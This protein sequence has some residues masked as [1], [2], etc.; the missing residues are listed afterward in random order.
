MTSPVLTAAEVA[1]PHMELI[2]AKEAARVLGLY[3]KG[4][5]PDPEKAKALLRTWGVAFLDLGPGRGRGL[6]WDRDAVIAAIQ[7]RMAGPKLR[8]VRRAKPE[9]TIF[10]MPTREAL[11]LL[12][13]RA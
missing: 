11:A 10:D 13:S 9:P 8:P 1:W 4:R 2:D 6:R 7:S 5:R 3:G 12:T